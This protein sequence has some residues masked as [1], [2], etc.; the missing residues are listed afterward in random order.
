MGASFT[1][2]PP[3]HSYDKLV[4]FNAIAAASL[5]V[6]SDGG[7]P[8]LSPTVA[9]SDTEWTSEDPVD[10]SKQADAQW[11]NVLKK[12]Q[13]PEITMVP[14]AT[15][16]ADGTPIPPATIIPDQDVVQAAIGVWSAAFGWGSSNAL[17]NDV[18]FAGGEQPIVW[19][20]FETLYMAS[21]VLSVES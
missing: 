21:P 3:R 14:P 6:F 9:Y 15:T 5:D 17:K 12:W 2:P 10:S 8:V 11:A 16:A 4:P 1:A 7:H 13:N 18:T 20:Q 19:E